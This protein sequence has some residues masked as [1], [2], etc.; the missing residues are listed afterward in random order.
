MR[1]G[2]RHSNPAVTKAST[3]VKTSDFAKAYAVALASYG[4]QV[5]GQ[6]G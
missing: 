6:V 4:A 3:Y 2:K 1:P 5:D